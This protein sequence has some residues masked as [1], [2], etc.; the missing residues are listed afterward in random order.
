M[1]TGPAP[2]ISR[3]PSWPATEDLGG[4]KIA[5]GSSPPGNTAWRPVRGVGGPGAYGSTRGRC[6]LM[7]GLL[8]SAMASLIPCRHISTVTYFS[9]LDKFRSVPATRQEGVLARTHEGEPGLPRGRSGLPPET[10]RAVQRERLLRSVIAA[11]AAS[12]FSDVTV[13]DIVRG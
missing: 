13:A 5:N 12:G 8:C 6:A 2:G 3:A 9:A 4:G 1:V 10:V 11:V 7:T